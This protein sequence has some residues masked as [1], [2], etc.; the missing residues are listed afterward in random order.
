MKI[1]TFAYKN[2]HFVIQS[3]LR[4][5]FCNI[6]ELE[7][8]SFRIDFKNKTITTSGKESKEWLRKKALIN[9]DEIES[10]LKEILI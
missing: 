6:C 5:D 8:D 4:N 9:V 3:Y 7:G 1:Y 2:F 10:H